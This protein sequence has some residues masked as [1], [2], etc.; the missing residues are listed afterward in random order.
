MA[1]KKKD[2]PVADA[3]G[4]APGDTLAPQ[5]TSLGAALTPDAITAEQLKAAITGVKPK[6]KPATPKKPRKPKAYKPLVSADAGPVA[7]EVKQLTD[8]EGASKAARIHVAGI[9][10][11]GLTYTETLDV[12]KPASYGVYGRKT[13]EHL[14]STARGVIQ[15]LNDV[16]ANMPDLVDGLSDDIPDLTDFDF[17]PLKK[18][19]T[20]LDV[21]KSDPRVAFEDFVGWFGGA[22]DRGRYDMAMIEAKRLQSGAARLRLPIDEFDHM[23][24][25]VEVFDKLVEPMGW[26]VKHQEV[27]EAALLTAR[28]DA[29]NDVIQSFNSLSQAKHK[30]AFTMAYGQYTQNLTD[31]MTMIVG[32]ADD[33]AKISES[34]KDK[35]HEQVVVFVDRASQKR[36]QIVIEMAELRAAS[37]DLRNTYLELL[38]S[39]TLWA[40][41]Q[42]RLT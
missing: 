37:E 41:S 5:S 38:K 12:T 18:K 11:G 10:W 2:K 22:D 33:L 7:P 15:I 28:K 36:N 27:P 16:L 30:S 19:R 8:M 40:S 31:L 4:D 32:Y 25:L 29:L 24:G 1:R 3:P 14:L 39:V 42:P 6:A 26:V 23:F 20:F 35:Q 34:L 9:E 21:F 13:H 17:E